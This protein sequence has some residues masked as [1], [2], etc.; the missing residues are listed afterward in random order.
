MS[1]PVTNQYKILI[2]IYALATEG[3]SG[4]LRAALEGLK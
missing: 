3:I 1:L 2:E 4:A